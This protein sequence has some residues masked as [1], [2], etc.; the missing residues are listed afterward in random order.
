LKKRF[1]SLLYSYLYYLNTTKD[2]NHE[3]QAI[4]LFCG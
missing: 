2:L 1:K 3:N 4:L